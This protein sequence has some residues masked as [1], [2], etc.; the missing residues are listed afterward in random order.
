MA[1]INRAITTSLNFDEVLDLITENAAQLVGAQVCLLLLVDHQGTLTI[2]SAK[3]VEPDLVKTFSGRME[4]DVIRQLQDALAIGAGETLV[5]VPVIAKQSLTG[6]LVIARVHPLNPD[7]QW[8]LSALA[9]QAAIALGNARLYEMEL[10]EAVRAR[11]LSQIALLRLAA[12]VESSDDA[13]V[14]KDLNGIINSWNKG[15]ERILGFTADEVIG[16]PVTILIPPDRMAE[17]TTILDRIRKGQRIEH[18]ETLRRRKDGT[19]INVSLTVSPIKNERGEVIGASK[20]A[21]DITRSKESQEQLR[22]AL[23]FDQTVMLSMGEGLYT[24]DSQYRVTFM[25]P[26]AQR[27]LGWTLDEIL[28]RNIHTVI[29]HTHPDGTDFPVAECESLRVLDHGNRVTEHEDFFIRKNGTF[30]DVVYS[31]AP[32][33]SDDQITGLVVV[34]RDITERKRAEEEIRFQAHLLNAVDQAVIATDLEGTVIFW[35]SFAEKLYGW[36]AAEALGANV[37]D[38][39]PSPDLREE[40][41]SILARLTSGHSWAGEFEVQRRDGTFFPALVNDSPILNDKGELI[42]I[43]GV[44]VDNTERRRAE[45][46]REDLL[47]REREARAE[48]ESANRLKD[49]FLATLSH[50]LRNPLNVV[51]GYSEILRRADESQPHSFVVKAAETIRRNALAQA[52]LVAD[53]LDLS[54]LQMGKLSLDRTPVS[55]ST[56]IKEAVE[57]VSD[58]VKAKDIRLSVHLDSEILVVEGDS[59]RLG[60]IAWNLLNNA[61]KFTPAKGEIRITLKHLGDDA[62]LVVEDSGL[63][64]AP[65]FLPH[66]FE[67]FRQADASSSRRQGGMGIGLALVKQLAEL[68]DGRVQADSVGVGHGAQFTVWL[69]LY[70][71]GAEGL[72]SEKVG[73]SGAL[74][75]KFILVV[76][77]SPES[78]EMLGKLLEIEGAFVDLARSGA[79]AL[80]IADQKRFDLVISDISMPEMDGYQLLRELR[81][82]PQMKDVPA[83]ALTGYGRTADI[84]RAHA[85]GFA[86]HLIK[87]IDIDLLLQIVRRLTE[88][89]GR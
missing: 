56:V 52:Q 19:L 25:N 29:H 4:E 64:I 18:F 68:H 65:E 61:V 86:E 66:V 50:E 53:L 43:V 39:M 49:E 45:K 8:Q 46:E 51:I 6:L 11:D 55:L 62:R 48:A 9:D 20:I 14:S 67:I 24:I 16:Q 72:P 88:E 87:P 42:G 58:E 73:A 3:G 1:E 10:A 34:F 27:L 47:L 23:E 28:G 37:L 2:R 75:S 33:R 5:S 38:M 74:R 76:D 54:R 60:Q 36:P 13:I 78:T 82:L 81:R 84:E 69:P 21:R 15:A 80:T 44:S 40:A 41:V 35:N 89:D 32:L 85:E 83:V 22:R 70:K 63:G 7:E 71:S 77:D 59:V 30:F 79:E 57:T 17:E 26:T 12:I 31:S